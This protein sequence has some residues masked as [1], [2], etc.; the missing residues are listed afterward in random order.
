MQ[1]ISGINPNTKNN[2]WNYYKDLASIVS[3]RESTYRTAL[4]ITAFDFP[5]I[6][7][8]AFRGPKKFIET[9]LEGLSAVISIGASP[10]INAFIAKMLAKFILP[11]EAQKDALHY[12]RFN[13]PE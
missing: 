8:D 9:F 4:D 10:Y 6:F 7:A 3:S 5:S 2:R 1:T 13:I 12:L 11:E